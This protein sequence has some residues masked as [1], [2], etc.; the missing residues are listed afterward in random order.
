MRHRH[1]Q[2]RICK[3]LVLPVIAEVPRREQ[4]SDGDDDK[5]DEDDL[6]G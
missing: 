4:M 2:T 5:S 3:R 1:E 6:D